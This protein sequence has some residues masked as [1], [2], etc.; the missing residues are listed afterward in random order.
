MGRV[1]DLMRL[2]RRLRSHV[3]RQTGAVMVEY[4]LIGSL[5]AAGT[6][7]GLTFVSSKMDGWLTSSG[8]SVASASSSATDPSGP[9]TTGTASVSCS[10]SACSVSVSGWTGAASY[11]YAWERSADG[12]GSSTGWSA[13]G[14]DSSSVPV[15][16]PGGYRVSVRAKNSSGMSDP[17]TA[18]VDV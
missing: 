9:P 10:S 14:G 15:S 6:I 18:C 17:V 11:T 5:I 8:K 7:G 12:C 13:A 2:L 16:S 3:V 1:H 4:V